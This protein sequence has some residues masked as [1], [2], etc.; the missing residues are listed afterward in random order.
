VWIQREGS[1]KKRIQRGDSGRNIHHADVSS[2]AIVAAPPW[3]GVAVIAS[4]RLAGIETSGE[5]LLV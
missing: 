1:G 2:R 5:S 3:P 4:D